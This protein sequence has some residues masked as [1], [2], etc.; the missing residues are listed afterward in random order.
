[1]ESILTFSL[2]DLTVETEN[3]SLSFRIGN[4]DPLTGIPNRRALEADF[5]NFTDLSDGRVTTL[6]AIELKNVLQINSTLGLEIADTVLVETAAR[7]RFLSHMYKSAIG[8]TSGVTFAAVTAFPE[9]SLTDG[10]DFIDDLKS[11]LSQ[12][13]PTVSDLI[14]PQF[15]VA[16]VSLNGMSFEDM[17]SSGKI[18]LH[19]NRVSDMEQISV[20]YF[21]AVQYKRFHRT[22]FLSER[23]RHSLDNDLFDI[24]YQP[25][26]DV[27]SH[28]IV[29][30]EALIRWHLPEEGYVSPAEFIPIAEQIGLITRLGQ[31]VRQSVIKQMEKWID[32]G[33]EIEVSI[34]IS[35]FELNNE[36]FNVNDFFKSL[37][38]RNVKQS[39]IS[40]E[41]TESAM[42]DLRKDT[43]EWFESMHKSNFRLAIDDF[44]VGYSSLAQLDKIKADYLKIDR[45]F[46]SELASDSNKFQMLSSVVDIA[47]NYGMKV[48]AE[49]VEDEEQLDLVT[50]LGCDY[51][52]GFYFHKPMPGRELTKLLSDGMALS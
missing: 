30:A 24:H 1:M 6:V 7:L 11:L 2:H 17:V 27:H 37:S 3:K 20:C 22:V 38:N 32:M 23:M 29:R 46:L 40:F 31:L 25:I 51:I 16:V 47:H 21:N 33:I 49:G 9:N 42:V 44:G 15:N 5:K 48:V 28:R 36:K 45:S 39:S 34:N 18:T 50:R 43:Q 4:I 13:Y 19:N 26:I 10:L 14:Q 35:P 8:K 52:Q 41:I 12:P